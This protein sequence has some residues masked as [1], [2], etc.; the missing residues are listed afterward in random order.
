MNHKIFY[1]V[2]FVLHY[3][4][5]DKI[6]KL[7][8][9]CGYRTSDFVDSVPWIA[10]IPLSPRTYNPDANVRCLGALI[11][12]R[13]VITSS[14]CLQFFVSKVKLGTSESQQE[15]NVDSWITNDDADIALFKLAHDIEFTNE[16]RPICLPFE[17]FTRF[18]KRTTF[19]VPGWTSNQTAIKIIKNA[20]VE[21]KN[22][23]NVCLKH[24][25][26]DYSCSGDEGSPVMDV[27]NDKHIIH[28][29]LTNV[30]DKDGTPCA[31]NSPSSG[32]IITNVVLKWILEQI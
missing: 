3:S 12:E 25:G 23:K 30:Y 6:E 18:S 28:G 24:T 4:N 15:I 31:V 11:S 13:Y 14:T 7:K 32:V 19:Y 17:E 16:I 5:G 9:V 22:K 10:F 8:N 20:A 21:C 26:K 1:T 27:Q 2:L 29:I